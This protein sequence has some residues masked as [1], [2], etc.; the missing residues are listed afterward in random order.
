MLPRKGCLFFGQKYILTKEQLPLLFVKNFLQIMKKNVLCLLLLSSKLW[1]Q[2]P[3]STKVVQ[4][5]E[6]L[7]QAT[8]VKEKAPFAFTN[9]KQ[10]ELQKLNLGQ[11]LPILLDQQ[12]SVVTT[13]DA[14]AGVGYTGLR[15]RGTD[16]T[17]INVTLNGIPY[18]DAE[19]QGTFWVN[20]PDFASSVQD[21]QLIR[22][23]GTSTNGSSTF[24]ASLNIKTSLPNTQASL[25]SQ[26]SVGSFGTRKHNLSL[27]TG[28]QNGWYGQARISQ[29][30]SDGFIDRASANLSS[31]FTEMGFMNEKNWLKAIVFGGKEKTY[32]AWYGTPEAVAK[33]DRAGIQ[34]FIDRNYISGAA[35]DNLLNSGRSYNFYT[36]DNET[37]N[38]EQNHYQLHYTRYFNEFWTA[39]LSLNLTKGKG[40][41]EQFREKDKLSKYFL[42]GSNDRGDV[43]RQRWLDNDFY[44]SVFSINYKK[45]NTEINLGGG[46]NEY[47]GKHFGDIIWNSFPTVLPINTRYYYSESLKKDFN[48]YGKINYLFQKKWNGFLDLQVRNVAY[49]TQGNNSDLMQ[50]NINE[51]FTFFNPKAGITYLHND[52]THFYT[53]IAVANRE[54]NRDDLTKNAIKPTPEQLIDFE[55]GFEYKK[56]KF[57]LSVNGYFMHYNNQLVLTGALDDV[58]DPIR[59]NVAKSYRAGIEIATGV[60][61]H[62]NLNWNGNI[63][64]S[65]NKIKEYNYIVYDTQYDPNTFETLSYQPISIQLKNTDIA[66][67]P[68]V[69]ASSVFNFSPFKNFQAQWISKFV[70]VQFLDNTS[71]SSKKIDAYFVQNLNFTYTWK[72]KWVKEISFNLLIN[73]LLSHEYESNG[74]TYSYFYRPLGSNDAATTENF[75]YPQAGIN[76]LSGITVSF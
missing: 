9:I 7:L 1:S 27:S 14:G 72:P 71:S 38:Y 39:N 49:Q 29:I 11:D 51:R 3:D 35:A 73:N 31:Y 50:F 25:N 70:S 59:E 56:P 68:N 37:D 6:V 5:Q 10:K 58:G 30:S 48:L 12:I 66:F 26:H 44:A 43:V 61:L 19:S 62:K 13:S 18:N 75:L 52:F 42:N 36:Y 32:Q 17:R 47:R 55:I 33:N 40:Y 24:G 67:S 34:A 2:T 41:F 28:L 4:L 74:Y 60:Y 63:T 21:I 8:R 23:V 54:P 53:S 69:V 20:L 16:A 76:F 15:I 46:Y 22:G 64:L 65:K 57:Q 45:N